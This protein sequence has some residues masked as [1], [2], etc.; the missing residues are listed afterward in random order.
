MGPLVTVPQG[1]VGLVLKFGKYAR[2]IDA[3]RYRY[4]ILSEEVVTVSMKTICLDVTPQACMTQDNLTVNVNAVCYYRVTDP[5]KAI[6]CV[7]NYGYAL[8]NLAQVTMRTVLGENDL[9]T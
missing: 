6:F 5:C 9:Q 4:N 8:N 7:E 2:K 1:S 3:G